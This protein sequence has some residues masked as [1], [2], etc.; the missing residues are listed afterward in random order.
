[1]P[2]SV[3]PFKLLL[4]SLE[5]LFTLRRL[6]LID[7]R[8]IEFN[9]MKYF[10]SDSS[11]DPIIITRI[12]SVDPTEV[13]FDE[14]L[15]YMRSLLQKEK[16]FIDIHVL[17]EGK[18]LGS[19]YRIKLGQFVKNEEQLIKKYKKAFIVVN[20]SII[21]ATMLKGIH[22]IQPPPVPNTVVGS[23]DDAYAWI[24]EKF[25][26]FLPAHVRQAGS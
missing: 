25:P 9:P 21:M 18:F 14:Y 6:A 7:L 13:L 3:A 15:S 20:S 24:K 4:T 2:S 23:L 11:N 8:Y 16:P 12:T 19:Q 10:V 17:S 1:M 22:L 5:P 26:S